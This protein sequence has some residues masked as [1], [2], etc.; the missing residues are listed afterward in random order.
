MAT[1]GSLEP[2]SPIFSSLLLTSDQRQDG[3]LEV[4]EISR[5]DLNATELAVLSACHSRTGELGDG[6]YIVAL[7]R[8]FLDAGA[9][10]VIASLWA[11]DDAAAARL[12]IDLHRH[13]GSGLTKAE[14]LQRAQQALRAAGSELDDPYYWA[15]FVLAGDRSPTP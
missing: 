8:A 12:M 7:H 4:H 10:S 1:H 6:E 11:V 9:K 15:P 2:F 13:L 3:R 5:L 14:S